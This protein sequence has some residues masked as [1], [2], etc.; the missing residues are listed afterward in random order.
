[1]AFGK[2]GPVG[3]ERLHGDEEEAQALQ[4]DLGVQV[5]GDQ[6]EAVLIARMTEEPPRVQVQLESGPIGDRLESDTS[7]S[8]GV[9]G[10]RTRRQV[11]GG[12]H[13]SADR[14]TWSAG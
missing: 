6:L 12:E 2:G 8:I 10:R 7:Q 3:R 11:R 13:S 4:G 9:T 14:T 5:S 1:M